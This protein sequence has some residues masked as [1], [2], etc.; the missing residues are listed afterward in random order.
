MLWIHLS[1]KW[2]KKLNSKDS[3]WINST[4]KAVFL[5]ALS[6]CLLLL[7]REQST[8]SRQEHWRSRDKSLLTKWR[9]TSTGVWVFFSPKTFGG[10][11]LKFLSKRCAHVRGDGRNP[12]H[13][14]KGICAALLRATYSAVPPGLPRCCHGDLSHVSKTSLCGDM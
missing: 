14:L 2:Q 11:T 6:L 7:E 9:E 5:K 1:K 13:A 10:C 8:V 12:A 3:V 4:C